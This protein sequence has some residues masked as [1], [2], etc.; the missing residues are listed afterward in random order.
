MHPLPACAFQV[1]V[2][3]TWESGGEDGTHSRSALPLYLLYHATK[4][5]I[6]MPIIFNIWEKMLSTESVLT[7]TS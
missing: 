3:Q 1:T 2:C 4:L 6:L 5:S 7:A